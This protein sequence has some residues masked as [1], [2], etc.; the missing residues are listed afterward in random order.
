MRMSALTKLSHLECVICKEKYPA[1]PNATT[2]PKCPEDANNPGI[3]DLV[4]SRDF[5]QE[6]SLQIRAIESSDRNAGIWAFES[7]L[8]VQ[9]NARRITLGEAHTPLVASPALASRIGM[10]PASL[11]LKNECQSPTGSL[12]DRIAPIVVAKALEANARTMVVISSGNMAN[13]VTAHGAAHGLR[14]VVIV[15]PSAR[16]DR[17]LHSAVSGGMV[18]RVRGSSSDRI[19][20]CSEAARRFGWYNA[21]SPYNPYGSHGAKTIAYEVFSRGEAFDWIVFP[22]GFGCN[23]VGVWKGFKDLQALGL[24]SR[25]PKFAAVQPEGSPSLVK[26]FEQG[27][28]EAVPG[29]QETIAGGI[30]QV[31][32]PNSMLALEA[33]YTTGGT[34]VAVSDEELIESVLMLAGTAGIFAEPAGAAALAGLKRL[35]HDGKIAETDRV[36]LLITGSGFKEPTPFDFIKTPRFPKIDPSVVMLEKVLPSAILKGS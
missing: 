17:V 11:W 21:T 2:C 23:I 34:A 12:K 20:L 24:L 32:T 26:A 29:P 9:S 14:T 35:L 1:L 5:F 31:A 30:S 19:A 22:V 3:L 18:L 15:S 13:A 10:E 6:K 27:L 25:I 16:P 8:P 28:K 4:Y 36:L 7:L 33:L